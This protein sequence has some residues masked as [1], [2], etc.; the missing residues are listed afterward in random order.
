MN[1]RE[2]LTYILRYAWFW[3]IEFW[4]RP[5][6]VM[7]RFKEAEWPEFI[8]AL[9]GGGFWGAFIGIIIWLINGDI[10][11]IWIMAVAVA[12]VE[13]VKT[14]SRVVEKTGL[15]TGLV[16]RAVTVVGAGMV[17]MVGM[18]IGAVAGSVAIAITIVGIRTGVVA[19]IVAGI[20]FLFIFDVVILI[21]LQLDLII[22]ASFSMSIIIVQIISIIN[23]IRNDNE[24]SNL[25]LFTTWIIGLPI[26]SFA[27][28]PKASIG[29]T[30]I[31]GFVLSCSFSIGI[32]IGFYNELYGA[33]KNPNLKVKNTSQLNLL[34]IFYSLFLVISLGL[35]LSA[36]IVY[37]VTDNN[38]LCKKFIILSI[39][40]AI[41]PIIGTGLPFYPFVAFQTI[42]QY[43]IPK[44]FISEKLHS[45]IA[46]RWQS[47]AYPLPKLRSY[48]VKIAKQYD[49]NTAFNAIQQVQLWTLQMAAS[50][51]AAQDLAS[52]KDTAISFC[53]EI[54]IQTNNITVLPLSTTGNIGCAI[55]I[56]TKPQDK[57]DEQPLRLWINKFPPQKTTK[58]LFGK[59][60]PSQNWLADFQTTRSK[61][62]SIRLNYAQ[63]R[64]II[65]HD[66]QYITEY[67]SLLTSLHQYAKIANIG[68]ILAIVEQPIS[69]QT[70]L[71]SIQGGWTILQKI[72]QQLI[73]FQY[74][75]QSDNSDARRQY[76]TRLQE[77]LKNIDWQNIPE[78]WANI[79]KE[80]A[81]DWVKVLETAK[82]QARNFLR[83]EINLI[84]NSL[85]PGKQTLNFRITNSTSVIAEKLQ[86]QVQETQAIFW[87]ISTDRHQLLEGSRHT[88]LQLKCDINEPGHYT[89]RGELQAQ[90]LDGNPFKQPFNFPITVAESGRIYTEPNYQLYIT[91]AGLSNDRTFVGRTELLT[92][93]GSRL[94][95]PDGK[96]AIV[97]IGQRRIGKT[98]LLNKIKRDSLARTNLIPIYIDTQEIGDKSE[99]SFLTAMSDRIA[100]TIGMESPTLKIPYQDF[101]NFLTATKEILDNHR[102]LIMIDESEPIFQGKFGSELPPFLR[103]LMQHADYPTLLLFCGTYFLKQV[104]WDYSSVFFNTAEFKTVSYLSA[105]E[106]AEV[107]QK[108][109]Q[110][111]LEFDDYVLEQAH[112]LTKGQP[113]LLQ[114]LGANIIEEFNAAVRAGEERS[115]YVNFNDLEHATQVLVQRQDNMAFVEHWKGSDIATHKILSVLAWA[116]DET[117]RPQL[118]ID[119]IA[120]ALTEHQF[121][122]PRKQLFDIIQRL[123]DEEILARVGVT[124]KFSVPLYRRWIAWRW[125]PIT[126]KEEGF[127][128]EN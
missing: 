81:E 112:I 93:I 71:T 1:T 58:S 13:A 31:W 97:L 89:I 8:A 123:L 110:D 63:Q 18:V 111:T 49:S 109:A 35:G 90:D 10:Y 86:I 23:I 25:A 15:R 116:T 2:F 87:N 9:V 62:L 26:V 22:I 100:Q 30:Y 34:S 75:R 127:D 126:V 69:A 24:W 117:N 113:L 37:I 120:T 78:Y 19:G 64:L 7:E 92:W 114:S 102:F 72:N 45:T 106:S 82:E 101:R 42:W 70:G 115:N 20:Y 65:L 55:A 107:L 16:A 3:P 43:H 38:D 94:R 27:F 125:E 56:L 51:R 128:V 61:N 66:Y 52:H 29:Q 14:V 104:A 124:Y 48:L 68:D 46:F 28:F 74:Y 17:G 50:R 36:F 84:Q 118:D 12:V 67:N 108:P 32:I 4:M 103:S 44:N 47:F 5:L 77:K 21:G 122:L 91:G 39:F 119:G 105:T 121:E 85:L 40:M 80:L 54:A 99:H 95:Q 33:K 41:A 98:S 59:I 76:I 60:Q 53:N 6:T 96:P 83:L 11:N 57:E 73:E 88:D 79:G